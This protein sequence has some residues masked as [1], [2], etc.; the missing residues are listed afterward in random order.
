MG[1]RSSSGSSSSSRRAQ[2]A[3]GKRAPERSSGGA[4]CP[5]GAAAAAAS[6][7]AR[8]G[9]SAAWARRAWPWPLPSA[10]RALR[11][12]RAPSLPGEC[13]AR[14]LPLEGPHRAPPLPC[15]GAAPASPCLGPRGTLRRVPPAPP[16]PSFYAGPGRAA[17]R[18]PCLILTSP[19]AP[20][21]QPV[22]QRCW[23][24]GEKAPGNERPQR[25]TAARAP[26]VGWVCTG[27]RGRSAN[28]RALPLPCEI[29]SLLLGLLSAETLEGAPKSRAR[30]LRATR[31]LSPG[32][33]GLLG[34][35]CGRL[36]AAGPLPGCRPE[37][38]VA[39]PLD[40]PGCLE[41]PEKPGLAVPLPVLLPAPAA[42]GAG[43]CGA[44]AAPLG[45]VTRTRC[46]ARPSLTTPSPRR[47]RRRRLRSSPCCPALLRPRANLGSGRATL[48]RLG[49]EHLLLSSLAPRLRAGGAAAARAVRSWRRGADAPGSSSLHFNSWPLWPLHTERE[50][51]CWSRRPGGGCAAQMCP[52]VLACGRDVGRTVVGPR[53]DKCENTS[54]WEMGCTE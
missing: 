7:G 6:A 3:P 41:S 1:V 29:R 31:P 18:P 19:R 51:S 24:P 23:D 22:A 16:N 11:A 33:G 47:R 17:T 42:P 46:S 53:V 2:P 28:C 8:P 38:S 9:L 52:G 10:S 48:A 5:P 50:A 25:R 21:A 26:R 20:P 39:C 35:S 44:R 49:F 14:P 13:L 27:A 30:F 54:E 45:G 43:D 40:S 15:P 36:L 12:L 32:A 37:E 34:A 4:A